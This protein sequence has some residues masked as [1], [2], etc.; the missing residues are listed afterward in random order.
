LTGLTNAGDDTPAV[1][2]AAVEKAPRPREATTGLVEQ[3]C[4]KCGASTLYRSKARTLHERVRRNLFVQRL[5]RCTTCE[6]RGWLLP[7]EFSDSEAV[8]PAALPDLTALDA[9]LQSK[10]PSARR[11]FSPNDLQ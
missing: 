1:E 4:P 9:A 6:W 3:P 7:L 2:P 5:F 8:Q 11:S 10:G